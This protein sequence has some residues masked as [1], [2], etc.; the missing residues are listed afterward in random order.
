ML[1]NIDL[2]D[3]VDK[4]GMID[5]VSKFPYQVEEALRLSENISLKLKR[6]IHNIVICGM[7]GSAISGDIIKEWL[8]ERVDV[9]I[10]VNRDYNPP[11]WVND[12][13]LAIFLSY[14]GNTEETLNS[15]RK[16][17]KRNSI[18]IGISSGGKLEEECEKASCTH[19]KI[20]SG[21]QPRAAI[22][23][24]LFPTIGVLKSMEIVSDIDGEI[25]ETL[26]VVKTL[27]ERNSKHVRE[28]N[29]E[30]KRI[31]LEICD[32]LPHIYGWR[33]YAPIAKRW[34]T[35][36]NENSKM[37]A[38]NDEVPECNH[39]DVV[40]WSTE[41]SIS[42]LS[43]CIF[44]R[45]RENEPMKIVKRFEFMKS[46]FSRAGAKVLEV[47]AVGNSLLSEM[48]SLLYVGDFVSCYLAILRGVD[49]TPVDVIAELKSI[50]ARI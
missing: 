5:T 14:S 29:N 12:K 45:D 3:E 1:D 32:T 9:P 22:A 31:A 6:E 36:I 30:A 17:L 47:N 8:R 43:C 34:R 37:I 11:K 13:T 33:Y 25:E 10:Y 19:I 28:E 24:L 48:L 26:S 16:A 27:S 46:V 38:R 7:G 20:P 39:N 50:L 21:Y 44:L 40:G 23:Y 49:P 18:C 4:S 42:N 35:Q 15:F 41:S 2:I